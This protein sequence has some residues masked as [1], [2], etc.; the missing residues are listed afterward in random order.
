M[1]SMNSPVQGASP[2]TPGNVAAA[3][4]SPGVPPSVV[5]GSPG[6]SQRTPAGS[7]HRTP[8]SMQLRGS[9]VGPSPA[10]SALGQRGQARVRADVNAGMEESST[11]NIHTFIW[12]TNIDVQ[13]TKA[14]VRLFYQGFTNDD[15]VVFVYP[16]LLAQ[17]HAK[18]FS[19]I[20]LDC[21]HVHQYNPAL[22]AKLVEY[23]MEAITI[24]DVVLTELYSESFQREDEEIAHNM[25][26]RTFNL[27]ESSVMRNLNPSDMDKLVSIKGMIIRTSAVIPDI[28]R[29]FFECNSCKGSE[30]VDVLNGRIQEPSSCKQCQA[31]HCMELVHNRCVFKDKQLVRLQE[32]PEDIPQ[33]ETPMTVN[34]C[35]FEDLVDICKPGDRVQITGI[36]RGQPMRV[37]ST[38][39]QL[40]SVYKTYID[41][42][43]FQRTD[44]TRM[45]EGEC[46][47]DQEDNQAEV[48]KLAKEA[49]CKALSQN[50]DV[51]QVLV[52]S[53]A[54]SIFEMEDVKK[55]LLCQLFGGSNFSKLGAGS[56]R[57]RA[58]IN[59]LLIGD[60]G[61]SKSQL[62]SYVHRIAPRGIYTSGK[63]SSAVGLT[64]YVTKDPET[65]EI[66]LES[67]ALVLSDRGIC[68]IDEFDKMSE[69][70]RAILHEAMEQQTIS[71]AK[72]GIICSL[73]AR[74]SILAAAN[75]IQSRYNPQLSVVENMALPP[76][77][78]SRFD[79]IY[80]VLDTPNPVTDR[81]LAK[82]LVAMYF[83][84]PPVRDTSTIL[85]IEQFA[86][87]VSYARNECH[88]TLTDAA[89]EKLTD[90]YVNMRRMSTTKNTI[91]ATPRQL[92]SLVR[93]AEAR[94]KMLLRDEV[95]VEDVEEAQRLLHSATLAAATDPR[96]GRIDMDLINTGRSASS[97]DRTQ[98][99]IKE[100][101]NEKN[102]ALGEVIKSGSVTFQELFDAV[103]QRTE[104]SD[105]SSQEL[106]AALRELVEDDY[107]VTSGRGRDQTIARA[108]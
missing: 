67:G 98:Q 89:V 21:R 61:V 51:I 56:G 53:F 102:G 30:D 16:Q 17:A 79:L 44:K 69:S 4:S 59:V 57:S 92:E 97:R 54:P 11:D 33:G 63:G 39:R 86:E 23:P 58:D 55:G 7:R 96:T 19:Y 35:A 105:I 93:L 24:F 74:T 25:Q 43:H 29:A 52:D 13:A 99:L 76:T 37:K 70:T 9:S 47:D 71:V 10:R 106:Q 104:I 5:P 83:E 45:G 81:K 27:Q 41:V 36:Y 15:S 87:Y 78:L 26:V 91:T 50:P 62:L 100:L 82:H 85:P 94:A 65:K 14:H 80:L 49:R 60:P 18:G 107:L 12:G 22:Y 2:G 1:S 66:V 32:N 8:G 84:H 6:S 38:Q 101:R 88:P 75:P 77:L 42:V 90:C 20:N 46:T 31:N 72:A 103:L 40:K 73:N 34:L 64:A 108:R 28:S 68:C 95:Q 3:T 48:D